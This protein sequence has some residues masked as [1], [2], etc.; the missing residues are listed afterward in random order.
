MK[1]GFFRAG[2][3]K[4]FALFGGFAALAVESFTATLAAKAF[5]VA[6]LRLVVFREA[7]IE[8]VFKAGIEGFGTEAGVVAGI[9]GGK[10]LV[11]LAAARCRFAAGGRN[12]RRIQHGGTQGGGFQL[13][14]FSET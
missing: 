6:E 14:E 4:G 8:A 9:S 10:A 2:S 3:A 5:A 13:G 1:A 11:W 12:R 7:A